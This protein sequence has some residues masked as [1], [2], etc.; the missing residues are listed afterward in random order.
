MKRKAIEISQEQTLEE[1]VYDYIKRWQGWENGE[2]VG[3]SCDH[4]NK[5]IVHLEKPRGKGSEQDFVALM[6]GMPSL[7]ESQQLWKGKIV[8]QIN[9]THNE[10]VEAKKLINNATDKGWRRVYALHPSAVR[11]NISRE[12]YTHMLEE[13][14]AV[15]DLLTIT[16][17][18]I[19][20]T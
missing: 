20:G 8:F 14:M 19:S 13:L 4:L 7:K 15:S 18:Q 17:K 12:E 16:Q 5:N 1:A 2:G 11:V 3:I 9:E 10:L 6:R